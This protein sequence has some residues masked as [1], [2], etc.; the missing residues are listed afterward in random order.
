MGTTKASIMSQKHYGGLNTIEP[1]L[2]H[3][4]PYLNYSLTELFLTLTTM[5]NY[6]PVEFENYFV[7]YLFGSSQKEKRA[8]ILFCN[9]EHL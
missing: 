9:F 2:V 1:I 4:F 3:F 8:V 7:I 5:S 6:V